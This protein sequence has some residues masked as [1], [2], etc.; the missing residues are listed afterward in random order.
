MSSIKTAVVVLNWN[1]RDFLEKFLTSVVAYSMDCAE[2]IVADNASSDDSVGF[3]KERHPQVRLIAFP[4]NGGFSRG[5]NDALGQIDAEYYVLLNSDVEVTENWL[6]PIIALMDADPTIAACQPKIRSFHER[7]K[8]EYA[9]AAG[10]FIDAYGYPFCRGRIFDVLEEDHGQYD[11]D[12][13]VFWAT[14]AC[15]FVRAEVYHALGGLDEDFFAHMEEIDFCWRLKNAGY[16]VMYCA[17]STVFHVGG[18][19]LPKASPR[20]TY[21]NFRN[22]LSLLVKNLPA[23]RLA[24]VLFIRYF[25]DVFAAL[26]FLAKGR[27]RDAAAVWSAHSHFLRSLPRCVAKRRALRQKAVGQ[28]YR[29]SLVF[30]HFVKRVTMFLELNPRKWQ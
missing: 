24:W 26:N 30:E 23:N 10:G 5:Y 22:N 2:V 12:C 25:F 18:G 8:F 20:K 15:L 7:E 17:S 14:G 13:E 27:R 21:L 19:A 3:L 29:G 4:E 1:G 16:K 6:A 9:G 11:D 28:V